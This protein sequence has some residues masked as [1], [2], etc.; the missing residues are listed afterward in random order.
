MK[1]KLA[2]AL[3]G[4]KKKVSSSNE[5]RVGNKVHVHRKHLHTEHSVEEIE[6]LAILIRKQIILTLLEAGSGHSAGPLGMA[7]VF[8]ALYFKLLNH[9]PTN[10]NW[11][12]R[13]RVILANGHIC[14]VL[15]ATLAEAGYFPKSELKTL[16]KL[17]SRLQGHP[18]YLANP[19]KTHQS[20]IA[21]LEYAKKLTHPENLPGVENTSG[22]LGQGL[23]QAIGVATAVKLNKKPVHV[24][25]LMS[26]G[27]LQEGQNW[28]AFLY[29]GNKNLHNLIVMIDRNHIQIDGYTEDVLPL[30]PVFEKFKKFNWNVVSINGNNVPAIIEAVEQAKNY[31]LGPSVIICE[32][33]PGKDVDFMENLPEWHGKPPNEKEAKDALDDLRS[34]KGKIW[35]E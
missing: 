31:R 18:H 23:S 22:P 3:T 1:H 14:P 8:A 29:A 10:P 15:Y 16:R 20:H 32:N 12:E 24:Y 4:S 33:T 25:C 26:D 30:E 6:A 28:E 2:Q 7:D 19:L 27:E 9:D 11:E 35:W 13:D 17:G 34:L 21:D 5:R